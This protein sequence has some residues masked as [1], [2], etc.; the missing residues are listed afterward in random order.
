MTKP[1]T[2]YIR[3]KTKYLL[4]AK[5]AGRC[6]LNGHNKILWRDDYTKKEMNFAEVAHIIGNSPRGPRGKPNLPPEYCNDIQ[7]LMLVCLDCHK[8]IDDEPENYP[9]DLL[10][11]T[12]EAHERRIEAQTSIDR[13]R[14]SNVIKFGANIEAHDAVINTS[15]VH[16]AMSLAGWY[17]ARAK[18]LKLGLV[19]STLQDCDPEFWAL[20]TKELER[21]FDRYIQPYIEEGSRNHFSVFALAPIPLLIKLG[22]LLSDVH[23]AEVYQLHR[24]PSTWEWQ[25]GPE[26]FEYIVEEPITSYETVA[27]IIA[28]SDRVREERIHWVSGK[29]EVSIWKLTID[30]PDKDFLK[31]REQLQLFRETFRKLLGD[32]MHKHGENVVI[33]LFPAMPVATAVE[34]GR[35]RQPKADLP[36]VIYDENK[37]LGGFIETISIGELPRRE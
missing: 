12:K 20:Q 15:D 4:W 2:R 7:N 10:R 23:P 25:D 17:P 28:L 31:S 30:E 3:N 21:Q 6:E 34:V 32:I 1:Y 18:P 26:D 24:E 27:L 29:E 13:N 33:H 22:S 8:L 37:T 9:D 11:N 5:A 14:T 16:Q 36:L 35:V 19:N